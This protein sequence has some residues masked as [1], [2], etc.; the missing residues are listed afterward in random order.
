MWEG[1]NF[2]KRKSNEVRS[3]SRKTIIQA[4]N[5]ITVKLNYI[6]HI[7]RA[8]IKSEVNIKCW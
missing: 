7:F 8:E 2:A 6:K 5:K 4:L 3:M 1:G